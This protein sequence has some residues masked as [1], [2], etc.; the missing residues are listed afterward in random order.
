MYLNSLRNEFTMIKNCEYCKKEFKGTAKKKFCSDRCR[1]FNFRAKNNQP[2]NPFVTKT[3]E[4]KSGL[5][6]L[7]GMFK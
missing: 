1:V 5:K 6:N 7:W 3:E 4:E 2:I